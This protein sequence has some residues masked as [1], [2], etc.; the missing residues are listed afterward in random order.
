MV[1]LFRSNIL[2]DVE[3][4]WLNQLNACLINVLDISYDLLVSSMANTMA[5]LH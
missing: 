2:Q 1:T 5:N 4:K 3:R